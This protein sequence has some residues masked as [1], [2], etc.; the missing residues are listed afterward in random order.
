MNDVS[1]Y[2]VT[3]HAVYMVYSLAMVGQIF[4][5]C[6]IKYASFILQAWVSV[7]TV[8]NTISLKYCQLAA[9]SI[10]NKSVNYLTSQ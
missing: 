3:E 8:L 6:Q 1:V 9:N 5:D 7:H 4:K 2:S 10:V